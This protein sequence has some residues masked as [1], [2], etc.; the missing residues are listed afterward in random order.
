MQTVTVSAAALRQV[1]VALNGP[2]H[3]IREL[4]ATRD[5]PPIMTGN[6][7]DQLVREFNDAVDRGALG[8]RE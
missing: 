1:L 6:P 5:K 4:Q 7:I 3:L 2:G 8:S